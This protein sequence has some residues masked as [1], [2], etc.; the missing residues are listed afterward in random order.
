MKDYS[1]SK[2]SPHTFSNSLTRYRFLLPVYLLLIHQTNNSR[3]KVLDACSVAL[4]YLTLRPHGLLALEIPLSVGFSRQEYWSW[5]PFPPP[6]DLPDSGIDPAPPAMAGRF[7]TTEPCRKPEVLACG[8]RHTP[9][10]RQLFFPL[11]P[12][13]L[14]PK[15]PQPPSSSSICIPPECSATH[16]SHHKHSDIF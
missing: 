11:P 6:G 2:T 10:L 7:F 9:A 8:V 12:S 5:L 3:A 14:R 16:S 15:L 4:S 1:I 13:H